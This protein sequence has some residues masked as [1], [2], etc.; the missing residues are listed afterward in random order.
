MKEHDRFKEHLATTENCNIIFSGKFGIGKTYFLNEFFKYREEYNHIRI[1]PVNYSIA[2]NEDIFKYINYDVIFELLGKD[3]SFDKIDFDA[4]SKVDAYL[5]EN[6]LE[7]VKKALSNFSKIGKSLNDLIDIIQ[8]INNFSDDIKE[9]DFES[10]QNYLEN[11]TN[12]KG[13]IYEE[14]F[15]LELIRKYIE[16]LEKDETES[17]L[18]I[19]DLDRLDPEHIFR[20]LNVFAAHLDLD[21]QTANHNKYGFSKIILVCDI[22]NIRNIFTN[23]YGQNVDFSGYIDKFYSKEVFEFDN[24]Q[25]L[26]DYI[27][28]KYRNRLKSF[29]NTPSYPLDDR[30][31]NFLLYLFRRSVDL[32]ILNFRI[33]KN[34]PSNIVFDSQ[35]KMR[36]IS[37]KDLGLMESNLSIQYFYFMEKILGFNK[38]QE[39]ISIIKNEDLKES[40][41]FRKGRVEYF[42]KQY[43][44][45][46]LFLNTINTHKFKTDTVFQYIVNE[47]KIEF[48]LRDHS[49]LYLIE[50]QNEDD[51]DLSSISHDFGFIIYEAFNQYQYILKAN[52]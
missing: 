7:L 4:E 27:N 23:R 11:E 41:F 10:F 38:L 6:K 8:S 2:Q 14:N 30:S 15:L 43:L 39:L 47:N 49:S 12:R 48:K 50:I 32:K 42:L 34:L 22:T 18:V 17:V 40:Y 45:H 35:D 25:N 29:F 20:I 33:L 9:D 5:S 44:R 51:L 46:I 24:V 16:A 3:I 28:E 31:T 13:S 52:S 36:H 19:D 26:L 1:A 37:Y 21:D